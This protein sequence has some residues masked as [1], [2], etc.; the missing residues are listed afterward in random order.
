[1]GN[2]LSTKGIYLSLG[3][4]LG[5]KTENLEQAYRLIRERIGPILK[6]SSNFETEPWGFEHDSNFLNTAIEIITN[7]SPFDLLERCQQIEREMGRIKT[8][9]GYE[10]RIIDIDILFYHQQ[11]IE[12]EKL[13]VPHPYIANRQFVLQPMAEIAPD[14]TH[15]TLQK[16]IA[17]ILSDCPDKTSVKK[18]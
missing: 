2:R 13:I 3:T 16:N 17:E 11:L 14:F 4:N 12:D 10:A 15:P 6:T 18:L 1:M 9:A 5:N 7:L 8:K